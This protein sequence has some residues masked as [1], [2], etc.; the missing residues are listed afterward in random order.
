[1]VQANLAQ[2]DYDAIAYQAFSISRDAASPTPLRRDWTSADDLRAVE[3]ELR[4]GHHF[5]IPDASRPW[6]WHFKPV[7][8]EMVGQDSVELPAV[9]GYNLHRRVPL[10]LYA[11][12]LTIYR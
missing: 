8:V 4:H 5:V 6:L 11:H 1:M 12:I 9:E 2:G 3:A 10:S 7:A